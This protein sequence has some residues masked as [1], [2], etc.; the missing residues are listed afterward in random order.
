MSGI[1]ARTMDPQ[2]SQNKVCHEM[3]TETELVSSFSL[4]PLL[5]LP[6]LAIFSVNKCQYLYLVYLKLTVT[7]AVR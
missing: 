6:H 2:M 5:N 3:N 7:A 1:F 4:S